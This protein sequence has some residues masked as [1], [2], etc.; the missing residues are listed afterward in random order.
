MMKGA[1]GDIESYRFVR[2]EWKKR[3]VNVPVEMELTIYVNQYE[4]V[5]ILCTPTKLNCLV[6][7]FL[8]SEGI[9]SSIKD[10]AS[11]RLCEDESVADVKLINRDFRLPAHRILTSGCGGG[12]SFKT[13]G[14]EIES[15]LFLEPQDVLYLMREFQKRM[16]LHRKSGGVHASALADRGK[17]IV[18]AEDIGRHNTLDKIIGECLLRGISFKDRIILT[19]GRVSSEMILKGLKIEAPFI[20]SRHSPT[21]KA[22]SI[23]DEMGISLIGHA[24][25]ES[26]SIYSHNERLRLSPV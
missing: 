14:K 20:I 24:R 4:L 5:Q 25:G 23:A 11:M 18:W 3:I 15:N 7:G 13:P 8:Y 2:G 10:V 1:K 12:T 17:I 22:I 26:F 19:T 16:D 6:M 9:I 21:E